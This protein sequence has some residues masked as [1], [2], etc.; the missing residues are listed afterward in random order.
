[1][2][3][4]EDCLT[5]LRRA[6]EEL[7]ESPSKAQYEKLGWTPASATIIRTLGSWNEAKEAAGLE[8][9]S[10]G[11]SRVEPKPDELELPDGMVWEE[12]TVDQRWHYRNV[13][14]NSQRTLERRKGI[15]VWV[16]EYKRESNG[17]QQCSETDPA[18]LDFHHLDG[19]EKE[20]TI[21]HM[22]TYGYSKNRVK[23][24]I[25]K[26]IL[27]CANCHRKE[28]YKRPVADKKR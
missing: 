22:I 3:T 8:T 7:G 6:S 19:D 11:G 26:C 15:R 25:R 27:L 28:H 13:E 14:R 1:M 20:M 10:S 5:V 24:E 16:Y 23:E 21:S 2:T 4:V 17:C 9:Y 12:L 18:C